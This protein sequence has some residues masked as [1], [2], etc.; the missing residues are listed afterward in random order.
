MIMLV[1]ANHILPNNDGFRQL[2]RLK[3]KFGQVL[4][5]AQVNAGFLH[6]PKATYLLLII[7]LTKQAMAN[8]HPGLQIG[9]PLLF[10][11]SRNEQIIIGQ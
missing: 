7:C 6:I 1:E 9:Q 11:L 2:P 5:Q 3:T 8:F 10:R 4:Q